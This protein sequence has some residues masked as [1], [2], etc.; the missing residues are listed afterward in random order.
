MCIISYTQVFQVFFQ[1]LITVRLDDSCCNLILNLFL[2]K[3]GT[4]FAVLSVKEKTPVMKER[5]NK[6]ADYFD[7]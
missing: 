4:T 1:Y 2:K 5:L 7:F 6:S 3:T